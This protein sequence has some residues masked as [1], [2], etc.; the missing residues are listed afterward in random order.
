MGYKQ[1]TMTKF[2]KRKR[3]GKWGTSATKRAKSNQYRFSLSKSDYG[4]PDRFK[5]KIR[6]CDVITFSDTAGTT[7][8]NTFR[9]NS[10]YDPDLSGVGHQPMYHDQLA[11]V[12]GRYRVTGSK[13]TIKFAMKSS[14]SLAAAEVG[15]TGVGIVCSANSSFASSG[16][17]TMMEQNNN[18]CKVLGDKSSGDSIV[19]CVQTFVPARD[20][21]NGAVDDSNASAFGNNPAQVFY[22]HA[23]KVDQGSVASNIKMYVTIEY[24]LEVFQRLEIAAS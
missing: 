21:G 1:T 5:T 24:A 7:Q 4:F 18:T 17:S 16:I 22:A 9:L 20:L 11:L 19:T 12:Y 14:P 8:S 13:I 6:Y 15:P 3:D 2:Q 10:I 23:F